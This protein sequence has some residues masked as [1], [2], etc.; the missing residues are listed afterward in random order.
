MI[1]NS[2]YSKNSKDSKNNKNSKNR[3]QKNWD[4]VNIENR[5]ISFKIILI[6]S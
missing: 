1:K 2:E 4:I 3:K 6:E 5:R